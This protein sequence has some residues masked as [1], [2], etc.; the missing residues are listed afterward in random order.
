MPI[1]SGHGFFIAPGELVRTVWATLVFGS[2][3]VAIVATARHRRWRCLLTYCLGLS[4]VVHA[5]DSA[6]FRLNGSHTWTFPVP[7]KHNNFLTLPAG[8]IQ[9]PG[10]DALRSL[11]EVLE[12]ERYRSVLVCGSATSAVFCAPHIAQFWRLRLLDGYVPGVPARLA[13]LPWPSASRSLRAISFSSPHQLPGP[14]LALLNVKYAVLVNPA[15]YYNVASDGGSRREARP[16]DVSVMV[17]PFPVVPR[18]F[19]AA[20]ARPVASVA[21]AAAALGLRSPPERWTPVTTESVVEGFPAAARFATEGVIHARYRHDLIDL[22]FDPIDHPRFL[23]LNELY[24]PRWRAVAGGREL[25]IFP[26]NVVMRGMLIPPGIGTVQLRFTPF[27]LTAP[28]ALL[29]AM[30]LLLLVGGHWIFR[31]RG[32]A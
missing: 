2:L 32:C 25:Q 14:L 22:A 11:H 30:S 18:A 5:F 29:L 31:R 12:V 4:M 24:H 3:F 21:E 9:V 20:G 28:A 7:F 23:V 26:T 1:D 17:N 10:P 27:L 15:L 8:H 13:A 16:S 19:F 6:F